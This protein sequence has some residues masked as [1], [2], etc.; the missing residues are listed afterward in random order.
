VTG[1]AVPAATPR[2][3]PA[4]PGARGPATVPGEPRQVRRVLVRLPD[5]WPLLALFGLFPLWWALGIGVL[6]F[7]V[8][9]VP[10]AV[11]LWRRRPVRL[12]PGFGLWALFLCWLVIGFFMLGANPVGTVPGSMASRS[13]AYS[14]RL[15][16]YLSLTVMLL[17]VGN[18]SRQELPVR[19]VV[20]LMAWMFGVTVAGGVLAILFPRFEF[21][22]ALEL[23]LPGALRSNTYVQTLV[24]PG[25]SQVQDVLGYAA[26]RP[27]APYEY[28]NFWGNNLNLTAIWFVC[29]AVLGGLA[30][31][32]AV[33]LSIVAVG[34]SL[35]VV[36]GVWSLNRGLWLGAALSVLYVAVR[37]TRQRRYGLMAAVAGTL[38][39]TVAAVP[40]TPLGDVIGSRLDNGRSDQIR[41]SLTSQ[42]IQVVN[43]SPVIGFGTTRTA[44]GSPESLAVGRSAACPQCGNFIIGSNGH[45]WQL[46]VSTGYVGTA[47]YFLFFLYGIWRYRH[48]GSPIGIAGSLC[49][50]LALFYSL[51]YN[52][53]ASPLAF[54]LLGYALLWRNEMDG[55]DA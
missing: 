40:L 43:R 52:A 36:T 53:V 11:H 42:A 17:Y 32:R 2:P 29:L 48:D 39:L 14:L 23:V 51:F 19:R 8:M 46:L 20:A 3:G 21:T 41:S 28:T 4:T 6:V 45:L 5:A 55:G 54:Y 37:L 34:L 47:L 26:P 44:Q 33:R 31:R 22:S 7:D 9:A 24:H 12:P 10:M 15:V 49:L 30:K 25:L 35:A 18:L 27:K 50:W 38:C 1:T 13:M 16:A